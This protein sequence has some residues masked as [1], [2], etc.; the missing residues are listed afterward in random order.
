MPARTNFLTAP[1]RTPRDSKGTR[2]IH[3]TKRKTQDH[4]PRSVGGFHAAH[5]ARGDVTIT[6]RGE[7]LACRAQNETRDELL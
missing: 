3:K 7:M 5:A 2:K 6:A 1:S 4:A